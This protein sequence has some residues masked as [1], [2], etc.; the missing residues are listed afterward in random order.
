MPSRQE[1]ERSLRERILVIDGAMGTMIQALRCSEED[2]RGKRFADHPRPLAGCNDLLAL[3]QPEAV[4][5]IH[6]AYLEAGADII[7]T[8]TFN[9]NAISLADYGLEA[10]AYEMN[11]AGAQVARRARSDYLRRAPDRPR[12]VAGAIGPTN[13][14]ASLS[15][16]V[17][18]PGYRA[19]T[20][21]ELVAA[22]YEQARGLVDGGVDLLLPETT[23]DTLNLKACLFAI[24]KLFDERGRSVP[25]LASVT[26]TDRSG[27]TLS[28]QTLEAF[29][30]SIAHAELFAVGMNCA[31]GPKEMA[32]HVAELSRL[33]PLP[34]FAYPNAGL[35]NEFGGYDMG[36]DEFARFVGE[37]ASAGWVNIVGGCCGTTPRHIAAVAEAVR[38]A[39][40]RV[41]P[42]PDGF[43]HLSGLE[44]LTIRPES[45]FI[46]IGER[47]NVAGS[48]RFARLIREEKY[49]EA[50]AV[51]REQV[52]G[53]AN[54][55][56]V[57]MDEA[58]LDSKRAM[59]VF[60]NHIAA[61]PEIARLPLMIDSSNFD[62]IEAGLKCMQGK[63]V[64]NSLSLK[65]GE[66]EFKRRARLVKRYGAAVVV[67]AFDEEG[68]ATTV[69]HRLRICKRAH[70]I[71]TEEIGFDEGDIIFD[72]NI[73]VVGTGIEEHNE[74]AVNFIEAARE[75]RRL[76]PRCHIS[77]GVSN[78]S[79]SFRGNDA[80]REAMHAAFLY[81]AIQAGMDM[82]IVNAGQLAV[83][84]Q[85]PRDLLER[86]EDVL[87]NR[88]P[89]ATERLLA[90]AEQI[91]GKGKVETG[92]EDWRKE[93][94]EQ[95]LAHAVIKGIV[96]HIEADLDEA[97]ARYP[98][99]LD[100]IEGPLMN[101]MNVVGDLFGEGKMF[102]PQVVKSARVMKKA[103]AYLTP[104]MEAEK[105]AARQ[106]GKQT[107]LVFATVK[108]DV[109]DI[110]KNI[111]GVVLGC[112]NY[113]VI[114][115]GVMVPAD[116][117][118]ETA[119]AEGADIVGLSGLI[120]PSLDEMV[121]VARE[122]DRRGLEVPL[123]I[124]GAT[125]SKRHTAVKIA[126]AYR[127]ETIH[128]IDA[129]RAVPVVGSLSNPETR[130]ALAEKNRAEQALL[131]EQYESRTAADL[132]T[133]DEARRRRL[134]IDWD[135]SLVAVP[136]FLGRQV[137]RDFPLAE[138]VPYIDW[139]P[140]FHAWEIRGRY[141]ELLDDPVRG[142]AARELL[143][144][145]RQLLDEIIARRLL[146]AHGV[147]GFYP[148]NAD[149]DDI[150]L[151]ADGTRARELTRFHT[152]RQQKESQRGKPQ[153]ALADFIA[154]RESG[155]TDY[156]GAFAVTA[157]HG[158]DE[159]VRR[160]ESEHDQYNAIM[161]KALADRLAEAFAEY[162]HKRARADWGYGKDENL[163]NA[164]LIAER[165]RG[166]RPAP[167]YP[168]CPDH[169]EKRILFSLL[170]VEEAT[171][172]TLTENFAMLPPA[173]VCGL[174]FANKEA[175]YFAVSA[176]GRD[177]VEAYAARKGMPVGEVERWLSPVLGYDPARLLSGSGSG[178][179]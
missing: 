173:S 105:K 128:V 72:T 106:Q 92:A 100:I 46:M 7:E 10:H 12:F 39:R 22:Y 120:T 153:Y 147:Y 152:L 117:I 176:V 174:Y 88:R 93:S 141:P 86:V 113:E 130:R 29:L 31:L 87:F 73:L 57:N 142:P 16:D 116:K 67:M 78:I 158:A 169:T 168:A 101:G 5:A 32:P 170:D 90:F 9:S 23:F 112:N 166:I 71:L 3:T 60:L 139:S 145:A 140:F 175:R 126:P 123:L 58:M 15:P 43:T 19:V 70:R 69:E 18:N 119:I 50:L 8:N 110:G 40:P 47:T 74:Y 111:V 149:G 35:P 135:E 66:E 146:T 38:A 179:G 99:P 81:H 129:S 155:L 89:D 127:H 102:L 41:P 59:A 76:Y 21:D 64:V 56:D 177:Q 131:R 82:G 14:T 49:E 121:H 30:T 68:Q 84:E 17:N 124:G 138:L 137:L 133:Y 61:E 97:L 33:A 2:F 115:L 94:V 77:G 96:D 143:A 125:T 91:K 27:R 159:L 109:H 6:R 114:D 45:N 132:L 75:L 165:Y 11:V 103:V 104:F 53:G 63:G 52:E 171:G 98:R 148:A 79:F 157:G 34:T 80:V 44:R 48:R 134:H 164:D 162:L 62:V 25:V 37:W 154:P 4:E 1:L 83:Y 107:K 95:R 36:P 108:G 150:V 151:Y 136:A 54:I 28:G 161:V 24:A 65:E 178:P 26:I 160:F 42:P 13:R 163:S 156:L 55:L 20:F 118:I 167:G 51:A 144:N 172:I 85:I 122:M